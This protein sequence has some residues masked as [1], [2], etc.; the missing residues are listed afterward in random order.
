MTILKHKKRGRE[1]ERGRENNIEFC[2][3]WKMKMFL[4]M[5]MKVKK[6]QKEF[7]RNKEAFILKIYQRSIFNRTG[8][9]L[10]V[11]APALL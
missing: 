4:F 7:V 1:V 10:V 8:F 5:A 9:D 2:G 11:L 6:K 3:C